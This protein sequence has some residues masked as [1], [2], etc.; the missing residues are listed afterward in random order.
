MW[1]DD[2]TQWAGSHDGLKSK[3]NLWADGRL[4]DF[5]AMK[6]CLQFLNATTWTELK[7]TVLFDALL[8]EQNPKSTPDTN[9]IRNQTEALFSPFSVPQAFPA[10]T[11][12]LP[13]LQNTILSSKPGKG[14][15]TRDKWHG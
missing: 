12:G 4:Q 2:T 9:F 10:H 1:D 6:P 8:S 15:Q 7:E 5:A 14:G 3:I 11:Q 13:A